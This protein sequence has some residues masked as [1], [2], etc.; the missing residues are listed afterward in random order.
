MHG[1]PVDL[2]PG[3]TAW[4]ERG[5]TRPSFQDAITSWMTGED[6]ER[7]VVPRGDVEGKLREVLAP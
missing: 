6:H 5:K 4:F 2:R 3:V 7:F 1:Q